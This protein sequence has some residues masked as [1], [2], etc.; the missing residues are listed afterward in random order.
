MAVAAPTGKA[1][2]RL[3]RSL[4]SGAP[5]GGALAP[6][7]LHALLG[8][9][10]DHRHRRGRSPLAARLVVCDETSMVDVA[11]LDELL[12]ALA[13][14]CRLLLVGDPDQLQSVD[15]GSVMGDLV[16]APSLSRTTLREV[17]RVE[18][19][20]AAA[21]AS[22]LELFADV[23]EGNGPRVLERLRADSPGTAFLPIGESPTTGALA[24]VLDEAVERAQSLARIAR[25]E[26]TA[27]LLE[28]LESVMVLCAQHEG[29]LG[30]RWW[31]DRIAERAGQRLGPVPGVGV[32]VLVTRTDRANGVVNGDTGLV[33]E[34]RRGAV[35][36]RPDRD[37]E[38]VPVATLTH[39]QPWWAMTIHK[40]QGSEFDHVVVVIPP[41]SRLVSRELLYTAL[42]RA[43]SR[44]SVV[45]RPEDVLD[46]VARPVRRL[47]GLTAA[48]ARWSSTP[49]R[50]IGP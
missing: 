21:R 15:L 36:H 22:L 1:A 27:S 45:A 20:S 42:T 7:T 47:T 32:P 9:G 40:S 38:D 41:G 18:G 37:L 13:P 34:S 8:I 31:S 6:T 25:G 29:P 43:R 23:R 26:E 12:G 49:R 5:G 35:L 28:V 50:T 4:A 3:A 30:R 2:E 10:P 11:T 19:A 16:A 17:R 39:W 48:V 44:V 14:E 46:A 24:T 33:R